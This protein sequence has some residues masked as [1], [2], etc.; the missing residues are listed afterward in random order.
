[1]TYP[2]IGFP[3]YSR[4]SPAGGRFL[5]SLSGLIASNPTTNPI[6][7]AGFSY[8]TLINL[9]TVPGG[10]YQVVVNWGFNSDGAVRFASVDFVPD[11]GNTNV[12]TFPVLGEWCTVEYFYFSG[13]SAVPQKTLIYGSQSPMMMPPLGATWG[14]YINDF[15]NVSGNSS[16]NLPASG[17][18]QGRYKLG[19]SN[20]AGNTWNVNVLQYNPSTAAYGLFYSFNG[21]VYGQSTTQEIAL[22]E[23][24][25]LL[26][27]YNTAA[28][29]VNFIISLIP[30]GP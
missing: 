25:V 27:I 22:V 3:D 15:P 16:I 29:A 17:C 18:A 6:S 4:L 30:F 24:P 10:N 9:G 20:G 19:I 13:P 11:A 23:A 21:S 1:V 12:V 26:Q 28:A 5:G 7:T 14:G 2:T 8:I